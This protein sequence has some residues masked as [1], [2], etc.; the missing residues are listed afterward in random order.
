MFDGVWH[1]LVVHPSGNYNRKAPYSI[2]KGA[3]DP[4]ESP[5]AAARR[6]TIEE[7]AVHPVIIAPLG[8]V[9]YTKSR[10]TV[11]CYLAG[12]F[13]PPP[14]KELKPGDWEVDRVVF[15]PADKAREMLHPDQRAFIDRALELE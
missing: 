1:Y 4:N 5:E 2:P 9:E 14:Q 15:L 10:K 11:I 7:T 3:V 6:E 13:S 8:Q 12:P